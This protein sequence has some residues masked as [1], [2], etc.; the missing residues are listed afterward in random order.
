MSV[1]LLTVA[2][3]R[4][5]PTEKTRETEESFGQHGSIPREIF[6]ASWAVE[7]TE[8]GQKMADKHFISPL[9]YGNCFPYDTS[10][11][12]DGIPCDELYTQV[13]RSGRH[14][15]HHHLLQT[16]YLLTGTRRNVNFFTTRLHGTLRCARTSSDRLSPSVRA[17]V[18][19]WH[20]G[21]DSLKNA[22][23][24]LAHG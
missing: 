9:R 11:T 14:H 12:R 24:A 18:R 1:V 10:S 5:P 19:S 4:E 15:L 16:L 17:R 6:T 2:S 21:W 20:L 13:L 8:G 22:F 3:T 23:V 7:I